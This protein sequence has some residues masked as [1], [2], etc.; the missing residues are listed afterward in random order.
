MPL[1]NAYVIVDWSATNRRS[2]GRADCIWIAH[3]SATA[4]KPTT[5]SPPSRTD[6]ELIIRAQL[7]PIVASNKERALVCADFGYGY[8]AGFTSLLSGV[9]CGALPPW[10]TVWQYL[11]EHLQDNLGTKPGHQP[12]NRSNRFEVASAINSMVSS[13]ASTG[14]FWCQFK[15]GV[16]TCIPQEQPP[17]PFACAGGPIAPLRITDRMAKSNTPFRLFGTGSVG[18]QVLTGIPRLNAIRFDPQFAACSAVWPFE[19]G[20]APKKDGTWLDSAIRIIHAEIYPSV[21]APLTDTI[22]DRGQ[23]RAMWHWARDLDASNALIHEFAIPPGIESG[24]AEDDI[25]RSEEGWI[26]G[27][28]G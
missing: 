20:W 10:R 8:P 12:T 27:C 14:P 16:Y 26:L 6:A 24:S 2:A 13:P 28:S 21:R 1:F 18:S 15:A 7:Q 23:V 17:Q 5:V 19:T 25:I 22:K 4:D 3:G 11:S 9:D